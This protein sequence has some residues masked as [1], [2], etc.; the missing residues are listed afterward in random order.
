MLGGKH[1]NAVQHN[2]WPSIKSIDL[3][4]AL[5]LLSCVPVY[6]DSHFRWETHKIRGVE[7]RI[8][9]QTNASAGIIKPEALSNEIHML[10]GFAF[11]T[12]LQNTS[13]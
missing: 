8:C 7:H 13:C 1:P 10:I 4:L 12:S 11:R 2:I 6:R 3:E 5:G 9:R